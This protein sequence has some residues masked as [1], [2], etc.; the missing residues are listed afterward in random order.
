MV[1]VKKMTPEIAAARV[2]NITASRIKDML[3]EGK[4]VTRAKYAAQLAAERMTGKPHRSAFT[5]ASI[6]HGN[7]MEA[8]ARMRYEIRNG[9]MVM[10]S[11]F[12]PH[13][14]IVRCG[15]TPDGTIGDDGLIEIKCPE[16]HTFVDYI[17]S[18]E[19]PRAY[20][21]QMLWQIA[22]T[23]RR[24]CDF[25]AFDPDLPDEDNFLQIRFIPT[26]EEI[27]TLEFEVIK[28]DLEVEAVIKE[29]ISK[30]KKA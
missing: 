21:L 15:A 23:K 26:P 11:D 8:H 16:S 13:P 17:M 10:E 1:M 3:A 6:D 25:V 27:K 24:W 12:V 4:G 19:I 14:Q 22:C 29:I 5:S 2:G 7:E 30:R 18:G 9:V 28:F 20:R